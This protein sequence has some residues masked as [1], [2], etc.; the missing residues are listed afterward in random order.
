MSIG[1]APPL[2]PSNPESPVA[3]SAAESL[4]AP[5]DDAS[6]PARPAPVIP[7]LAEAPAAEPPAPAEPPLP[8]DLPRIDE[9]AALSAIDASA[10][11]RGEWSDSEHAA[12]RSA[13]RSKLRFIF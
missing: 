3:P 7:P 12:V 8:G 9:S 2:A 10:R 1:G 4:G 5:S 13:D 6:D 11:A